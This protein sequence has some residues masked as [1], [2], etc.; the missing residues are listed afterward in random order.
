MGHEGDNHISSFNMG[1]WQVHQQILLK[2]GV[3]TAFTYREYSVP[4]M[5]DGFLLW[6]VPGDVDSKDGIITWL[7][8]ELEPLRRQ[9]EDAQR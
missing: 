8:Y 3:Y 6:L 2:W 9:R 4:D 7:E 1:L 5:R